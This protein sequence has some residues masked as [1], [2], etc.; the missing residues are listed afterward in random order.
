MSRVHEYA[1]CSS[2]TLGHQGAQGPS[3]PLM[4]C[5][6]K[7]LVVQ[8]FK[9]GPGE[10]LS[11]GGQQATV[12]TVAAAAA[13]GTPLHY[14]PHMGSHAGW[15]FACCH[16]MVGSSPCWP[17]RALSCQ[18]Q[19][20]HNFPADRVIGSTP[21]LSSRFHRSDAPPGGHWP[22]LHQ[23]RHLDAEPGAGGPAATLQDHLR[24]RL[25]GTLA[26]QAPR[27]RRCQPHI[28]RVTWHAAALP[29]C[30]PLRRS[31]D[32]RCWAHSIGRRKAPTWPWWRA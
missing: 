18:Q 12:P 6:Q 7:G 1:R 17:H 27:S 9:C 15:G 13:G 22:T 25:A 4:S 8:A 2:P 5:R 21:S 28:P 31:P 32:P 16:H 3:P 14:C 29:T 30:A 23:S 20:G 10:L 24:S 26:Q 19:G 11:S